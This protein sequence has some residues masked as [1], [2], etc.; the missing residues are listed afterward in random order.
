MFLQ[1]TICIVGELFLS[2]VSAL[3]R[4]PLLLEA[5]A[6]DGLAGA[7]LLFEPLPGGQPGKPSADS[8]QV[9]TL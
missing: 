5:A 7:E 8:W 2:Q 3:D 6:D 4:Q 9:H 1:E